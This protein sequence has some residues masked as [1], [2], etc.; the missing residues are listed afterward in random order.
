MESYGEMQGFLGLDLDLSKID[1]DLRFKKIKGR[2]MP[3]E[4]GNFEGVLPMARPFQKLEGAVIFEDREGKD[5]IV[6]ISEITAAECE[7][8]WMD[9]PMVAF[10]FAIWRGALTATLLAASVTGGDKVRP[11]TVVFGN[12]GALMDRR[13]F[14]EL[15]PPKKVI[16]LARVAEKTEDGKFNTADNKFWIVAKDRFAPYGFVNGI[17]FSVIPEPLHKKMRNP[18]SK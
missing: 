1:S 12:G 9:D 8:H 11:E 13:G 4:R 2:L 3:G 17:S 7:G 15:T 14:S 6:S 16:C 10:I 18:K 5:A